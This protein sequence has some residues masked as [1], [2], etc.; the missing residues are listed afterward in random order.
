MDTKVNYTVVGIFVIVLS[1]AFIVLFFWLSA[2]RAAKEYSTY[3]TYM[4]EDVTGLSVQS[5]VRYNGVQV[6]YVSVIELDPRNP[7]L[8][9]LTLQVVEGTPV[10]KSTVATLLPMGITGVIYVGLKALTPKAHL[11]RTKP[12][13]KHPIIPSEP[14]LLKQLSKIL[15]EL[16]DN[17]KRVGDSITKLLSKKNRK[18]ID[19]TLQN[20][21]TL[22][23]NLA[24]NSKRLDSISKSL[25]ETLKNAAVASKQLPNLA[26]KL[27]AT[28]QSIRQTSIEIRG[29]SH[30]AKLVMQEGRVTVENVNDQILPSVQ[31]MLVKLHA[32]MSNLQQVSADMERN[33]SMF[34]RGKAPAQPGPGEKQK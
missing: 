34:I 5:A 3:L 19:A 14:S 26:D 22:T 29:I 2:T 11:L 18:A 13:E 15:P 27:S 23:K 31:Q 32:I 1:A 21:S 24:D 7:Q 10:T 4:H 12:G 28:L 16:T 9:R 25:E 33:P 6:G 20:V 17:L 8:V 30:S